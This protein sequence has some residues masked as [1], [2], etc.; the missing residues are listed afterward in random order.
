MPAPRCR[1]ART[2]FN[3]VYELQAGIKSLCNDLE[4]RRQAVDQAVANGIAAKLHPSAI[5]ANIYNSDDTEWESYA[6]PA[7]DTRLQAGFVAF[8]QE[9]GRMIEQWLQPR[10]A[11]GL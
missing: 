9:L 1:A 7:R 2:D 10:S 4:D 6:T 11:R 3:P 8:R 5:P